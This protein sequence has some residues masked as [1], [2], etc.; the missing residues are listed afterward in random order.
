MNVLKANDKTASFFLAFNRTEYDDRYVLEVY[1]F[2]IF[3]QT[4]LPKRIYEYLLGHEFCIWTI[5]NRI[6]IKKKEIL[7]TSTNIFVRPSDQKMR[8]CQTCLSTGGM[9][10]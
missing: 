4:K 1:T 8:R 2:E 3:V 6:S 9:V 7:S 5:A 10:S